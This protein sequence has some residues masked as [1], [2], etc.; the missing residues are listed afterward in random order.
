MIISVFMAIRFFKKENSR[1]VIKALAI[2]PTYLVVLFVVMVGYRLIFIEGSELD[3]EKSNIS[4]NIDFT[5]TAYNVKIDEKELNSTGTI[6]ADEAEKNEDVINNIP[7]IT[8]DV[9]LSNLKQTQTSTGYYTYNQVGVANYKNKLM[10]VSAREINSKN[11]TYNSEANEYT[12]G[13]GAIQVSASETDENGNIKYLSKDFESKDIKEPRIYYG[14]ETNSIINVS[15]NKDE[16]D[17][18][19]T[20]SQNET[21]KYNG[22]GGISLGRLDKAILSVKEKKLSILFSSKDSKILLNRN[23]RDRAKKIMPY[24]LYD[25]EPYLVIGEDSNLYWVLDAYTVCNEYPYSQKTKITYENDSREINYI[26]NS[27]KVI[28]DAFNGDINFYI[29]DKTDPMAMVYNNMYE[30][31]F[32]EASEIPEG[33][34]KHFSYSKFLYSIQSEILTMYH[35]VSPDV[36]YRGNDVW[37]IASYSNL[38]NTTAKSRMKPYYT[39]V[40]TTDSNKSKLGLVTVYN[41]YEKESINAYL[42]GTVENGENKLSLYKF[43]NDSSVIGPMQLD[44]LIEQDDT[45]S[46]EISSLNVT[47]T[48]ITKEMVIV[49]INE[50]LIYVIPIYQTSLNETNSVPILKKVVI[51]SGNKV[52]IGD[53]LAEALKNL[54]SNSSVSIEVEDTDTVEG[55]IEQIIKANNNLTESNNSNDW[56]QIGTDIQELQRLIKQLEVVS[57]NEKDK[58]NENIDSNNVVTE[59][60]ESNNINNQNILN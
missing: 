1:K 3:K 20:T 23:I 50:T 26:R 30:N 38:T 53:T 60:S 13:Y 37:Q 16:F 6:T 12:H 35:D 29:T 9:V 8:E 46:S 2:V 43:S 5:K 18:P 25:E 52:A 28:V 45:I 41:I 47:G 33:I 10:Y 54:L 17:Y 39:M 19:K 36:L 49:P 7:I 55:L 15:E 48:K 22:D 32:K 11:T 56:S 4:A 44:K 58:E 59:D 27:V 57:Q 42:V 21:Y 51:A 34:S 40:K 24:L 31:L 14:M